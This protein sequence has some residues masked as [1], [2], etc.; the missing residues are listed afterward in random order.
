MRRGW[1]TLTLWL[2]VGAAAAQGGSARVV[3]F[4]FEGGIE[5]WWGNPWGGGECKV[6]GSADAK[7]GQ[8]A[9]L[10]TYRD[11]EKG[12]NGV[13]PYFPEDAPWRSQPWG[14][15]SFWLKGD[16]SPGH[17]VIH[18]ETNQ[19]GSTGFSAQ[20]PLES[21]DWQRVDIPFHTFWSRE[22][23][24]IDPARLRRV[25]FGCTGT[26]DVLIDQIALEAPGEPALLDADPAVRPGP[27]NGTLQAPAVSVLADGRVEV[28]AD[29]S[30]LDADRTTLRAT[31]KTLADEEC[32]AEVTLGQEERQAGEAS[33]LLAPTVT[34]DGTARIAVELASGAD[35]LAA[36]GYTFPVFA[37]QREL[38]KPSIAIYPVPKEIRRTEGRLR[39]GKTV[40]ACGSGMEP[41]DLRRTLGM[42]AR[43]MQAYYGREVTVAEGGEGQVMA[44]V[45]EHADGLPKGLLPGAL[46]KRLA[47]V[48]EEG[49]VLHV[50]P[51]RAAIA[52]RSAAGLYY[53]LQSLLAAIDDETKLPAEAA[54]P[55]CEIVDWPT[56]PFRGATMSNPT[57]RWG[58]PN[59]AW[60]DVGYVNDFVYRTMARQKL[61][62]V[63]FIIGEGMQF[64]SHPELRAPNAWRKAEIKRFI[65]FC[66]DNYIE[67]IPLVTVL[68][69]AN[70][71][72]IPH[73]ELREAGHDENIACVRHPDTNPLIAEV[74]DE[75]IDLF[76]PTT[77]HIGMDEC[78]WRTLSLPEAE[79]CPRC[80]SDWPDIVADQAILFHD[81]LAQRNIRAMMWGDMLLPEHNGGPPYHTWKAL[82]RI[83]R[84]MLIA[85]WSS[86]LAGDSNKRFRDLGLG[87]VR[88][89]SVGVPRNDQAYVIGNMQGL[90]NKMPWLTDT[91]FR[92]S[93]EFSYVSLI[94]SAE[95]SWNVDPRLGGRGLDR[96]LL[97]ERAGSV[98]R[99]IAL[100]PS[101][102]EGLAQTPLDLSA[103]ANLRADGS[104]EPAIN[105]SPLPQGEVTAARTRFALPTDR[106][107]IALSAVGQEAM[108]PLNRP[109]AE[110]RLLVACHVAESDVEAFGKQF[111]K[112]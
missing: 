31:L 25:Y 66:R 107:V 77:F 109:A 82:E 2:A 33:L 41:D 80:K 78:W 90:W 29:L 67:V 34:Q 13:S 17:V 88:S 46:A 57:S 71:F 94:P 51:E 92:G 59:D 68:G 3:V 85:N 53:G 100:Q 48:G 11:V 9:L 12:A 106:K 96:G 19:E 30:A 39:F 93:V 1:V 81:H 45:A 60:V 15:L 10:C 111:R 52:A 5:G 20:R 22:G 44:A 49:Y 89:N 63:V 101:P 79:R 58:Y 27:L 91:Y 70:W 99:R 61:N 16:G 62:N 84:D 32:K 108:V 43:E 14:G 50:T 56:F 73:P 4:D 37:P 23:L 98:L 6:A 95:F 64:D 72:C 83:P 110:V 97:D 38:T 55:C 35:R 105:L 69:H 18:V 47:D 112:Q 103:A 102:S 40:R 65:D 86:T 28:R 7:F 54:A 104:G 42:F 87:V 26:H 74:F 21:T 24:S 36:W 8:G 75:V 76:Q